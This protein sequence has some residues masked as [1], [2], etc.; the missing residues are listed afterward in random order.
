MKLKEIKFDLLPVTDRC[1][2]KNLLRNSFLLNSALESAV[3]D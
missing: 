3:N 2:T 1:R